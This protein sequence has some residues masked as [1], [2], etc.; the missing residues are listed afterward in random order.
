VSG[1]SL[2][3]IGLAMRF[4]Y[5]LRRDFGAKFFGGPNFDSRNVLPFHNFAKLFVIWVKKH[6]GCAESLMA[7]A[8]FGHRTW[9]GIKC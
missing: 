7:L 5:A 3:L 9:T 4:L 2:F 6:L 8:F 1:F